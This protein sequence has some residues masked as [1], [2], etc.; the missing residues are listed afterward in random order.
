MS[1]QAVNMALG[2][3]YTNKI[4]HPRL[5]EAMTSTPRENFVPPQ[6]AKSAYS[7]APLPYGN[8]RFMLEPL[9][10][11]EMLSLAHLSSTDNVL[12]VGAGLGYTVALASKLASMVVGVEVDSALANSARVLLAPYA[13]K[14]RVEHVN[15]LTEGY[16]NH[17]P[18]DA[19]LIEGAITYV[20]QALLAQLKLGGRLTAISPM[21][22]PSAGV[23]GL[24]RLTLYTQTAEGLERLE[25]L[26]CSA[27]ML[28]DF[29]TPPHFTL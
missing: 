24:G 4:Q 15:S 3:L 20:P 11:A 16:E 12:V 27:P 25:T 9:I 8:G 22:M 29:E 5:L 28:P 18:Y 23:C 13:P 21:S 2:Q 17:A 14:A 1:T 7:D 19:I 6:F 10:T 26:E